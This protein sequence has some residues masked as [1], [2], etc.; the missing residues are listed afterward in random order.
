MR[1]NDRHVYFYYEDDKEYGEISIP[2]N[3]TALL[4]IDMQHVFIT[5][6]S[7]GDSDSERSRAEKWE[8]FYSK[9]DEV[10]I[11]NNEKLLQCFR[12]NSMEVIFAKIESQTQNGRE[13]SLDQKSA[14]PS[15]QWSKCRGEAVE[16][17]VPHPVWHSGLRQPKGRPFRREGV[18][19]RRSWHPVP[20]LSAI[21]A[22]QPGIHR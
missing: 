15:L 22:R 13:R 14:V 16:K 9:I 10:V 3:S 19:P 17:S 2:K 12:E 1:V 7:Y 6:P 11:P 21:P 20:S 8:Q 5:R 18:H 4:V